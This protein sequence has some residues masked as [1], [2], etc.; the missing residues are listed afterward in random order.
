VWSS[1]KA[2]IEVVERLRTRPESKTFGQVETE[3]G[4]TWSSIVPYKK[5]AIPLSTVDGLLKAMLVLSRTANHILQTR[6]AETSVNKRFSQSKIQILRLLGRHGA[7]TSTQVARFLGV[8]KPA[9]TQII[10]TMSRAKLVVRRTAT[11]DRREVRLE[12]T[13]KGRETFQ[14]MRQQQRRFI[15]GAL[16]Q[17]PGLDTEDW[18]KTLTDMS[19]ALMGVDDCFEHHC[20][21]CSAYED[22][23]CVLE[24]GDATCSYLEHATDGLEA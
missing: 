7:Q 21:Q 17:M 16:K 20:L 12:L 11:R 3:L 19:A 4:E 9:V 1:K 22:S 5:K 10:D 15:R 8:S 6:A 18:A 23:T 13:K 24:G 2:D 14:A